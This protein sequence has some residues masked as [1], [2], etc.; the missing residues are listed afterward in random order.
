MQGVTQ[1]DVVFTQGYVKPFVIF[2]KLAG[3]NDIFWA[4]SI[5]KALGEIQL[6][7]QTASCGHWLQY[8]RTVVT[9]HDFKDLSATQFHPWMMLTKIEE[10]LPLDCGLLTQMMNGHVSEY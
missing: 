8:M 3:K 5:R 10:L 7:A 4:T 2:E 9:S 1:N 6:E